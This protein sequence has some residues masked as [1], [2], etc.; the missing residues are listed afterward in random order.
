MTIQLWDASKLTLL[1]S[2]DV[3]GSKTPGT[4]A[5]FGKA[6]LTESFTLLHSVCSE[7]HSPPLF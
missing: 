3:A 7:W 5:H 1:A 4:A 6:H 2:Q